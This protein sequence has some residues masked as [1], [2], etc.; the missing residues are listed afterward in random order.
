MKTCAEN[1]EKQR[2]LNQK[3][4]PRTRGRVPT[5]TPA[6]AKVRGA[7]H[8]LI[9]LLAFFLAGSSPS[10]FSSAPSAGR[11]AAAELSHG[12]CYRSVLVAARSGVRGGERN[13]KREGEEGVDSRA[14]ALGAIAAGL[15]AAGVRCDNLE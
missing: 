8:F 1:P 11:G 3:M 7:Q 10:F 15:E 2:T 12:N 6:T 14:I 4:S 13:E 9:S 5:S